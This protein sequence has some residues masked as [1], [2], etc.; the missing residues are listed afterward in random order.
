MSISMPL[1]WPDL[2]VSF[3]CSAD[4]LSLINLSVWGELDALAVSPL[5]SPHLP[6]ACLGFQGTHISVEEMG[7]IL[8]K[9]I[10]IH[11]H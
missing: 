3:I 8:A 10:L 5:A 7:S 4:S 1:L 11:Y 9:T 2:Q 6:L